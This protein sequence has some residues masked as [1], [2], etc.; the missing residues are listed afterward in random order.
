M[1]SLVSMVF[2]ERP[3][4]ALG[5]WERLFRRLLLVVTVSL[6]FDMERAN[7][8][9]NRNAFLLVA[10]VQSLDEFVLDQKA[11]DKFPPSKNNREVD[12]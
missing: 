10:L 6:R 4:S 5:F 8:E 3:G 1:L 9:W 7:R 12:A 11:V 2:L